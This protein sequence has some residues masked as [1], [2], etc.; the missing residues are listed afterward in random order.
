VDAAWS[1]LACLGS[2]LL[3]AR[4]ARL[5]V[6]RTRVDD[7][8]TDERRAIYVAVQRLVSRGETVDRLSVYREAQY[9]EPRVPSTAILDLEEA[10]PSAANVETYIRHVADASARRKVKAICQRVVTETD[11]AEQPLAVTV[12][13]L[14]EDL[15]VATNGDGADGDL[16][17]VRIDA[18]LSAWRTSF[19]VAAPRLLSLGLPNIDHLLAGGCEPGEF[20]VL[21]GRQGTGKTAL[22]LEIAVAS[23]TQGGVLFVSREMRIRKLLNRILAQVGRLPALELRSGRLT[24]QT[25]GRLTAALGKLSPLP[26]WLDDRATTI[27]QVAR[28]VDRW[29]FTPALGL[30]VVDYLQLVRA[31]KEV[32]ERR[33]QVELVSAELKA[34]AM[35]AGCVVLALS[36]MARPEREHHDRRPVISDLRESGQIDHDADVVLLLH[37]EFDKAETECIVAKSRDASVGICKLRFTAEYVAFDQPDPE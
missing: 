19:D 7:Y 8:A 2:C 37:R 25:Y 15:D 17:P 4:A 31:P 26:L 12:R 24:A 5:V 20:V 29:P 14:A 23:A 9:R 16:V 10:V 28:M 18:A 36:S 32:K 34:I 33:H 35:R 30:V 21:G 27:E 11:D 6:E 1:E 3:D 22:A 13:H